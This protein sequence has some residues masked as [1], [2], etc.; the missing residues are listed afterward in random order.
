MEYRH[1][2]QICIYF[3]VT[4]VE[5]MLKNEDRDFK[6]GLLKFRSKF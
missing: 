2:I 6:K 5:L 3:R 4:S 1:F